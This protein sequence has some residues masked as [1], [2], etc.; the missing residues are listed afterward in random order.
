MTGQV[1][2]R[3]AYTPYGAVQHGQGNATPNPFTY[4]GRD[5]VEDDVNGLY[6]MQSRYY[7]PELMRFI[8]KD[9]NYGGEL[10]NLQSLNRY[11]YV[12]GNPIDRTD[13]DGDFAVWGSVVGA[14][15]GAV[16]ELSTQVVP[17]LI[18]VAFEGKSF[19]EV[20]V[21]WEDDGAAAV[22]GAIA[23]MC[24]TCGLA[25]TVALGAAGSIAKYAIGARDG[26][27][28]AGTIT[29]VLNAGAEGAAF[30][31]A[32][33]YV[34][35]INFKGKGKLLKKIEGI[36]EDAAVAGVDAMFAYRK[37]LAPKAEAAFKKELRRTDFA[38][39]EAVER[40]RSKIY[41]EHV[42][43]PSHKVFDQARSDV[44]GHPYSATVSSSLGSVE[45]W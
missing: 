41:R 42:Q 23:G 8:Q 40:T 37:K 28:D 12:E 26:R 9:A 22:E 36:D 33:H 44:F 6:Y 4:V 29:N 27:L 34:G 1:T 15:I 13:P 14:S 25:G 35:K 7:A 17:Q 24:P 43:E 18:E 30:A 45:W 3:Y 5:G 31:G 11:A 2:D 38:S 16:V 10:E 39:Q 19:D 20:S 21:D 32:G